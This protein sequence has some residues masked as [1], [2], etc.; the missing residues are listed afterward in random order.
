MAL[1]A[2]STQATGIPELAAGI[3]ASIRRDTVAEQLRRL[4]PAALDRLEDVL[5]S[6]LESILADLVETGHEHLAAIRRFLLEPQETYSIEELA[7]LWH[8][9]QH[10]ERFILEI[11]EG[12]HPRLFD[13]PGTYA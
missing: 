6:V 4:T 5:R 7:A 13:D 8:L 2:A 10:V 12:E 9:A 3:A 1:P 11:F